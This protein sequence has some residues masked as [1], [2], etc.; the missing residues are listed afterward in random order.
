MK[1][2][3]QPSLT[4]F[5]AYLERWGL[6]PDGPSILTANAQLLPVRRD[7][8]PAI[9]KMTSDEDE[10]RG[11]ALMAWW[12]GDGAAQVLAFDGHA[13]LLERAVGSPTLSERSRDG[14]DDEAIQ[15]LCAV[16][17]R[18]HAPRRKAHPDLLS[19]AD[20]F[21]DLEP[22]AAS[23]GGFLNQSL[24]AMRELLSSEREA[25]V[26]HGDLHHD[27][28]LDFGLG[29]GWLAIDPKGLIGERGF[30]FAPLFLNPD[31]AEPS[32]PVATDQ[33][34]FLHRL[35][36]VAELGKLDCRRL[37]K[38]ILAWS[39]LS[40]VWSTDDTAAVQVAVTIAR[41]AEAELN[42]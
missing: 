38:W 16:A 11:S 31:L 20:W 4:A 1:M 18:L 41:F 7:D 3:L 10:R 6:L 8:L 21:R 34:R 14:H 30:D 22:A 23:R 36:L 13:L 40:S 12:A 19:L 25:T 26:L 29:R 9:L 15:T 24:A 2:K 27:N 42:R 39:G 28:V 5:Q 35:Q 32:R 37:L 33:A 17:A